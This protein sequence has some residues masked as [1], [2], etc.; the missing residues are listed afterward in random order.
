M[1]EAAAGRSPGG[2]EMTFMGHLRELRR[3]LWVGLVVVAAAVG[4]AFALRSHIM[5]WLLAPFFDAWTKVGGLPGRPALNYANPV[6]PF[7]V[8]MKLAI[9]AG[10]FTGLPLL[11]WQ[12]WLFIAPGLYRRERR[13]VYPFLF[14]AYLFF[15]AGASFCYFVVLPVAYEFFFRYALS[16][17][18]GV[19]INPVVMINDYAGLSLK[20]MAGFGV[21]FELP[22]VVVLLTLMGVTGWRQLLRVWRWVV[23]GAFGVAAILTPTPDIV[24]QTLM[25]VPLLVLY[26]LSI[27]VSFILRPGGAAG[28]R[29]AAK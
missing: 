4:A 27:L 20:L 2:P 8:D 17:G 5:R 19:A 26:F 13:L 15:V 9:L 24:N 16:M 21:V 22:V 7:F 29:K 12:L 28:E 11:I 14:F 6:D 3:R 1:P 18:G 25:A 10:L 23:V